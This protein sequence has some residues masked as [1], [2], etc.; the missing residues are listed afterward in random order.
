MGPIRE[1]PTG[2]KIDLP[3]P[4]EYEADISLIKEKIL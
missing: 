4:G 1:D 3:G 2:E